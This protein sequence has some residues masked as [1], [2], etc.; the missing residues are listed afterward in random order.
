MTVKLF[1]PLAYVALLLIAIIAAFLTVRTLESSVGY[2]VPIVLYVVA[3]LLVAGVALYLGGRA[4]LRLEDLGRPRLVDHLRRCAFL[5]SLFLPLS[6]LLVVFVDL[7]DPGGG[8]SLAVML[9][10][11]AGYAILIDALLLFGVTRRSRSPLPGRL[12]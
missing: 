6:V 7:S 4:L 9:C 11:A 10:V 5:Y 8:G 3:E 2:G 1:S 12:S